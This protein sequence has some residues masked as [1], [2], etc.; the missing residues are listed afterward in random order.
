MITL[1]SPNNSAGILVSPPSSSFKVFASSGLVLFESPS[2]L[3]QF[4]LVAH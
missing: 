4:Q 1:S 2:P 3:L